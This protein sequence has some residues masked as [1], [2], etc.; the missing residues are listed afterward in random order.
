MNALE[1]IMEINLDEVWSERNPNLRLEKI[2]SLYAHDAVLYEM[3]EEIKGHE[4]INNRVT[5]LLESLP[6]DFSFKMQKPG[7]VNKDMGR[8]LWTAGAAGQPPAQT[9]MDVI[10]FEADKIKSLYVF[11]DK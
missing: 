11:L 10:L 6:P 1:Q 7:M 8:L 3:G 2:R 9:G 4:A 5:A